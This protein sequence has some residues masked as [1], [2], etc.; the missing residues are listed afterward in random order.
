MGAGVGQRGWV[1]GRRQRWGWW[2]GHLGK[3]K[4]RYISLFTV[5]DQWIVPIEMYL[6]SGISINKDIMHIAH[7]THGNVTTS[8]TSSCK[9]ITKQTMNVIATFCDWRS[10]SGVS[11]D[12]E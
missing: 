10:E 6:H 3:D 8:I 1:T 11:K 5:I 9:L 4:T 12:L 7:I 2:W